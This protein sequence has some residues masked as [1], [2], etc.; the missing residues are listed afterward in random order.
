MLNSPLHREQREKYRE[1][2][3]AGVLVESQLEDMTKERDEALQ[4]E[5]DQLAALRQELAAKTEELAATLEATAA[6]DE[7]AEAAV[8]AGQEAFSFANATVAQLEKD[9]RE[10]QEQNGAM[11][12]R[13]VHI[14]IECNCIIIGEACGNKNLRVHSCDCTQ[15]C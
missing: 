3:E 7:A 13:A 15:R 2:E 9:L 10:A 11:Q 1:C 5:G 14:I 6:E 12:Q 8:A 4:N